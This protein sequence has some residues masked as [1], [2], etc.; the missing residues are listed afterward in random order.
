MRVQAWDSISQP[1][2][3]RR[4][5]APPAQQRRQQMLAAATVTVAPLVH[6]LI[7]QGWLLCHGQRGSARAMTFH[8][9]YFLSEGS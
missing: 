5:G 6:G 4:L 3:L 1:S 2:Q 8:M 7:S 9:L